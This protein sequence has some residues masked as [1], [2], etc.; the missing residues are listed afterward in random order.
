[1]KNTRKY[2]AL[3]LAMLM[4]LCLAA[5][6][7]GDNGGGESSTPESFEGLVKEVQLA[8]NYSMYFGTWQDGTGRKLVIEANDAG[9]EVRFTLYTGDENEIEASGFIQAVADYSADYFYNEHDGIAHH[10]WF[11]DDGTLNVDYFGAFTR[12]GDDDEP[13]PAGASSLAGIWYLDGD[14]NAESSLQISMDGKWM[15]YETHDGA[16]SL[17]DS[18]TISETDD[19]TVFYA[20][21]EQFD[22]VSY[23]FT[24]AGSDTLYWG[25]EYDCYMKAA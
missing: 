22:D 7:D 3:M 13:A 23:D 15:L 25:G 21:S 19:E 10:S 9:D 4:C 16:I 18:G 14:E 5:C 20:V 1:M 6:G 11:D 8:S 2:L 12:G 17:I 24:L